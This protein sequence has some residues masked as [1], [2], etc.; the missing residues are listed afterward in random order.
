MHNVEGCQPQPGLHE[1]ATRLQSIIRAS[2]LSASM[3]IVGWWGH[4]SVIAQAQLRSLAAFCLTV[5]SVAS[6]MDKSNMCT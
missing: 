3:G 4:P 6:D 1:G 5:V 2:V